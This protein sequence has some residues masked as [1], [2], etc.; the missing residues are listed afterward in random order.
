MLV[1]NERTVQV[2][3][4]ERFGVLYGA[5]RECPVL[6]ACLAQWQALAGDRR[7]LQDLAHRHDRRGECRD[8]RLLGGGELG[9][10]SLH[11]V[12]S[13]NEVGECGRSWNFSRIGHQKTAKTRLH[14]VSQREWCRATENSNDCGESCRDVH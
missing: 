2:A 3:D 9:G 13:G 1:K 5:S 11:L 4:R 14:Y 10:V 6:H 7:K 12:T 8:A